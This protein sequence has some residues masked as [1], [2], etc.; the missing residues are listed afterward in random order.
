[1]P[2]QREKKRHRSTPAHRDWRALAGVLKNRWVLVPGATLAL[3]ALAGGAGL[4]LQTT[5]SGPRGIYRFADSPVER[6]SLVIVCAPPAAAVFGAERGYLSPGP[7]DESVAPLLK[8]VVALPGDV[9]ELTRSGVSVNGFRVSGTE[10]LERDSKGRPL[11]H[12]PWGEHLVEPGTV[13]VLSTYSP[14]SFDSRYF[15]PVPMERVLS[16][17]DGVLTEADF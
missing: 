2:R 16:V 5:E 10:I 11:P 7:C 12:P 13:W 9:V 1:M 15:G 6:G 3:L 4:R 17:A 8:T 14:L